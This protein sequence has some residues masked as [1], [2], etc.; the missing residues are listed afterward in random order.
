MEP[1]EVQTLSNLALVIVVLGSRP[2]LL[3][4]RRCEPNPVSG[5]DPRTSTSKTILTFPP[6]F[7]PSRS[8]HPHPALSPALTRRRP[9]DC[10]LPVPYSSQPRAP[11]VQRSISPRDRRDTHDFKDTAPLTRGPAS[12]WERGR[13]SPSLL[14][15]RTRYVR[16]P[17]SPTAATE[18][19]MRLGGP[20]LV[21]SPLAGR[22]HKR[23][24]VR[25]PRGPESQ[26]TEQDSHCLNRV[27]EFIYNEVPGLR[28]RRTRGQFL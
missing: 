19:A 21:S 12:K 17:P 4:V 20:Y 11:S 23:H 7:C 25:I 10:E 9:R 18:V 26:S 2:G 8:S 24:D 22:P 13:T 6:H 28:K 15:S 3:G 16:S 27:G 5:R 14:P 1:K